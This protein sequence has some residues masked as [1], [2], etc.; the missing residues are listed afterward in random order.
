M[1]GGIVW[2]RMASKPNKRLLAKG[3]KGLVY[4][5]QDRNGFAGLFQPHELERIENVF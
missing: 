1:T 4:A 2:V 5:T 3:W